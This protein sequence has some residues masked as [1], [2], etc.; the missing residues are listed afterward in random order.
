LGHITPAELRELVVHQHV[1]PER[2]D[3]DQASQLTDEVWQL[4][5]H[6]WVHDPLKRPTVD[7][8]C[9]DI[10]SILQS[11]KIPLQ[12]SPEH[13]EANETGPGRQDTYNEE[14]AE[15]RQVPS[16]DLLENSIPPSLT[17]TSQPQSSPASEITHLASFG[18]SPDRGGPLALQP[19][20][21]D[22]QNPSTSATIANILTDS[23]P[24]QL[25]Q[26]EHGGDRELE[27]EKQQTSHDADSVP[28]SQGTS[29]KTLA[30]NPTLSRN[31][32]HV[33]DVP[34]EPPRISRA[35]TAAAQWERDRQQR[36]RQ[37]QHLV[38]ERLELESRLSTRSKDSIIC[39]VC[40]RDGN[41]RVSAT[42]DGR[43]QLYNVD[44]K[45]GEVIDIGPALEGHTGILRIVFSPDGKKLA[46]A[47]HDGIVRLWD[48]DTGQT[49]GSA[50]KGH[51]SM[52]HHLVFSP[53]GK[54]LAS[55]SYNERVQLWDA[56]TGEAIGSLK[57]QVEAVF[58]VVFSDDGNKLALLLFD[59]MVQI[60][61]IGRAVTS[62][63][64][65]LPTGVGHIR[66]FRNGKLIVTSGL[67]LSERL[68]LSFYCVVEPAYTLRIEPG[69][70]SVHW[71]I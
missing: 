37:Q 8:I 17:T 35:S 30:R 63:F 6:C 1:R 68:L 25:E 59:G 26:E 70:S 18:G 55:T 62:A 58:H 16:N 38:W 60:W 33:A 69:I 46:S 15:Y 50:L 43:M 27:Q 39:V 14:L 67:A 19:Q 44:P 65:C 57:G 48:V 34:P 52:I 56:S 12:G 51:T 11:S 47:S 4:V 32:S 23:H 42:S 22:H 13:Y 24:V 64:M 41:K 2:P 36:Q 66:Y 21:A 40:S 3:D 31:P 29:V 7:A 61:D 49:I 45:T 9:D 54:K 10:H 71:D 5:E 20:D 53:D 28:P